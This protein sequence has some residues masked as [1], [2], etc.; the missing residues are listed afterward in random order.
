LAANP[1]SIPTLSPSHLALATAKACM[2][3]PRS[4][5]RCFLAEYYSAVGPSLPI[6]LVAAS[7]LSLVI[8][9]IVVTT[10]RSYDLDQ[11]SV[12]LLLRT[13]VLELIPMLSA[14]WVVVRYCL[15]RGMSLVR[16][17]NLADEA[18]PVV[19]AGG[20]AAL[21]YTFV[22]AVLVLVY[23]YGVLHGLTPWAFS[24]FTHQLGKV[25]AVD[26]LLIFSLKTLF[27]CFAG[28][29]ISV[30]SAL[31]ARVAP[32]EPKDISFRILTRIFLAFLF[33]EMLALG[34][35][36]FGV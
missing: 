24:G 36:Y 6:F 33:V 28:P 15:P 31:R 3:L 4:Q 13:L 35:V 11:Y 16:S 18:V 2:G 19:L 32:G 5:R 22:S 20:L 30:L 9:Q 23:S 14:L 21:F 25:L 1:S 17:P 7:L 26:V 12:Q 34:G 29:W 8:I 10:A 27:F